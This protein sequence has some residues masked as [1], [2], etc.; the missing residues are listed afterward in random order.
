MCIC[1]AVCAT[2][3]PRMHVKRV[4]LGGH[5]I[6]PSLKKKIYFLGYS[7]VH[8]VQTSQLV[9]TTI[10]DIMCVLVCGAVR[11]T[12]PPR[13]HVKRVGLDCQ[14]HLSIAQKICFSWMYT[15]MHAHTQLVYTI[16]EQCMY[17]Q[18]STCYT[19]T[20]NAC[21]NTIIYQSYRY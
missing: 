16:L 9:Y 1:G 12:L 17:L 21:S 6:S 2:L 7:F 8:T 3:I 10:L 19:V 4:G 14:Y 13:M 5:Y 11:A 18:C 20:K 15:C